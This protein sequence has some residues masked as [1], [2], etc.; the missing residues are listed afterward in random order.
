MW[1]SSTAT[2]SPARAP[3]SPMWTSPSPVTP[4][5]AAEIFTTPTTAET[6]ALCTARRSS[7]S[8]RGRTPAPR[9]RRKSTS[10]PTPLGK[11]TRP[12]TP[13]AST[14]SSSRMRSS[15]KAR[16]SVWWASPTISMRRSETPRPSGTRWPPV[17]KPAS[18]S[19]SA[20]SMAPPPSPPSATKTS[21]AA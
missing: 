16:R 6:T 5:T 3:S 4:S 12:P 13:S 8:W 21:S 9:R 11:R 17:R 20:P 1:T 14:R 7:P 2:V 18:W 10:T 15:P 19:G